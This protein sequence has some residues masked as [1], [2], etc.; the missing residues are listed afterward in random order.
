MEK[1]QVIVI[2]TILT[3]MM[4][5]NGHAQTY[6]FTCTV[7]NQTVLGTDFYYDIY[8]QNTHPTD[9][10]WLGNCD[11]PLTFD[12]SNFSAATAIMTQLGLPNS[13]LETYYGGDAVILTVGSSHVVMLNLL[14]PSPTPQNFTSRVELILPNQIAPGTYIGTVKVSTISNPSGTMNLQWRT[15][16]PNEVVVSTFLTPNLQQ[17]A[18]TSSGIYLNPTNAP[19]PVE[20]ISFSAYNQDDHVHLH[21]E[22]A[23]E[24]NN[25]GFEVQRIEEG[26][27]WETV[28]FVPGHGTVQYPQIYDYD[29]PLEGLAIPLAQ[30]KMIRYRL[31]QVD[32]D[33]TFEYSPVVDVAF[34]VL[35]GQLSVA[36]YPNPS[37]ERAAASVHLAEECAVGIAVYDMTGREM[38]TLAD[39]KLLPAGNHVFEIPAH[40]LA[41]GMYI[42]RVIGGSTFK[43]RTFVV[44]HSH[45][46]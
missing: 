44:T 4:G 11:F 23:M 29:D 5:T 26:R 13:K 21:W 7:Q 12:H 30:Q 37:S 1:K 20:L 32:R 46:R 27:D 3:M 19:L 16:A 41:E 18:I 8:L 31:R 25:Y 38:L 39:A 36:V 17:I 14:P 15:T 40:A 9:S 24:L 35:P 33:G 2:L 22:T 6:Q 43:A 10:I 42:L 28:G 45:T 34:R